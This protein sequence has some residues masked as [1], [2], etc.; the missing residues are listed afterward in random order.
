MCPEIS[1][2]PRTSSDRR[3]AAP[4]GS[5]G[6]CCLRLHRHDQ[7]RPSN[8]QTCQ[9]LRQKGVPLRAGSRMSRAYSRTD[10]QIAV[11]GETDC[12]GACPSRIAGVRGRHHAPRTGRDA[13]R[14][15]AS[16]ISR[17][18]RARVESQQPKPRVVRLCESPAT[19]VQDRGRSPP[20]DYRMSRVRRNLN[21]AVSGRQRLQPHGAR[22]ARGPTGLID[23]SSPVVSGGAS[24]RA[25]RLRGPRTATHQVI[26]L[27]PSSHRG[28][29]PEGASLPAR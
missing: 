1:D 21:V 19:R 24:E 14:G 25:R 27:R 6:S 26:L 18:A 20:R 5:V 10:R 4:R 13:P 9:R 22:I 11:R 16:E 7:Q 28:L 15:R 12:H 3:G 2:P 17:S 29:P 8:E 23:D